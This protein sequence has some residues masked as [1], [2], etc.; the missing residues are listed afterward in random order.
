MKTRHAIVALALL[1][2]SCKTRNE[3]SAL[4]ITSVIPATASASGSGATATVSCTFLPATIEFTPYLPYNPVE[5]RGIVAAVVQNN[6]TSTINLNPIL[7]A[8]ST[9]FLAHQA[10]VDYEFI[11]ASAGTPPGQATIPTSGIEVA[12]GAKGTIGIDMFAGSAITV[13][14][15]TIIRVTFHLDGKLLDGSL[16]HTSEREYLFR[17]CNTTGCGLGGPWAAASAAGPLVSCL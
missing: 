17:F 4:A 9:T 3:N 12:T 6:L 8:E 7:R 15:G 13:P 2:A 5:N 1:L 14:N 16:V 10:V 11:P